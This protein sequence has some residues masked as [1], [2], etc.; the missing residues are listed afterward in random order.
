MV[1]LDKQSLFV[2]NVDSS[3]F[4]E[5]KCN[6]NL[7]TIINAKEKLEAIGLIKTYV[8]KGDINDFVYELYSPFSAVEFFSN[9]ILS[10]SLFSNIG[11]SEYDRLVNF[12]KLP[13]ISM[14]GYEDITCKFNDIFE[15]KDFTSYEKIN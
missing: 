9:P 6:K 5:C 15:I 13:K 14:N 1:Y 3:S 11:K 4:N 10:V 2:I 7:S 12:Y 8:K